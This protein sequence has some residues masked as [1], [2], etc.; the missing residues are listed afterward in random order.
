[1]KSPISKFLF[2]AI[3][4]FGFLCNVRADDGKCQF[5][6]G[7][8]DIGN[9]K[10]AYLN[11]GSGKPVVLLHGLFAQKE[12]W[13]DLACQLSKGGFHIYMPDLPGYGQ[14]TGFAIADYR[15][16]QQV[17]LIHLFT[18]KLNLKAF[19]LAGNSMGGA[20]AALFANRY[21]NE[22]VTLGF[23]GAPM[24]I[25]S[26][27]D[28]IKGALYQGVN[29]FIPI[30]IDQFDLEMRLLF[31]NPL[32]IDQSVKES[33]IKEYSVN[34]R[35]YQQV[36]DIVNLD[37]AVL[38]PLEKSHKPTFIVWGQDDGIFNVSGRVRLDKKY[39]KANSLSMANA[40]H[41]IMLE[42][43]NEI[44]KL[45]QDFSYSNKQN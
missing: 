13:N 5:I 37:I 22:V 40:S 12:Q 1:M 14:S 26:W 10:I 9:G 21:P 20:I 16:S 27:S 31:A 43:P 29:P 33:A 41:L 11:I 17:E 4:W 2:L 34:N 44:A 8:V 39:P 24:G 23:I 32:K 45:Y 38:E 6:P 42:K 3:L 25:V 30:T 19:N 28:Q 18:Q 35:H 36:W 15:L 7:S